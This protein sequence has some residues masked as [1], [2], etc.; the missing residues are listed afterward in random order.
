M[1]NELYNTD[2]EQYNTD[3]DDDVS[4]EDESAKDN[5]TTINDMIQYMNERRTV[6]FRPKHQGGRS[7]K[8]TNA[9]PYV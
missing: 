9:Y 4:I 1:D 6:K 3:N 7:P 2:N 8:C 5:Y